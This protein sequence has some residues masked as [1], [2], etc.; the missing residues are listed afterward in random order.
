[1]VIEDTVKVKS[2]MCGNVYSAKKFA[3]D[4]RISI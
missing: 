4:L 3:Y 1:M 2:I